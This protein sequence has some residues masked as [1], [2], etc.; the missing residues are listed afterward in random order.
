MIGEQINK[1]SY[2]NVSTKVPPY[3]AELLNILAKQRGMEV[4]ELLQL[5]IN[6]FITAAK[7]DGPMSPELKTMIEAIQVD[8]S[9]QNAF[10]FTGISSTTEIEQ[11]VLILRQRNFH[12]HPKD[13]YGIAMIDRPF[14]GGTKMTVCVDDILERVAEVSMRGLYKNL[15]QIGVFLN[16][17]SLRETLTLMCDAQIIQHLD[18]EFAEEMPGVGNFHD[19]GKAIEYGKKCKRKPHRTPDSLANSKQQTIVF[20]DDDREQARAE[21]ERD[22]EN[23]VGFRPFTDEW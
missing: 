1:E 22:D 2:V 10:S 20:D 3:V 16:T 5:L 23:N 8:S 7:A 13:G 18:E 11:A 14:C 19:Y 21:A 6:G 9:W 15:R 17:Q 4:Y 12:G